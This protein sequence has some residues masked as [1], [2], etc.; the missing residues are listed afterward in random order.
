MVRTITSNT[1]QL[2]RVY[3]YTMS[4]IIDLFIHKKSK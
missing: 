4:M 3:E 1:L 2:K